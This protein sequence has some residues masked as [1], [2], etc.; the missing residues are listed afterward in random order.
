MELYRS[1]QFSSI[2]NRTYNSRQTLFLR[3][4]H[5]IITLISNHYKKQ[6]SKI[7]QPQPTF[8]WTKYDHPDAILPKE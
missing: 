1:N 8:Q 5:D 6:Q 7:I 2:P 3:N 4:Q